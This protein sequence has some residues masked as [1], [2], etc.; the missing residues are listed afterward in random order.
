M[1]SYACKPSIRLHYC[2]IKMTVLLIEKHLL[3]S[4]LAS[5]SIK[6]IIG[7]VLFGRHFYFSEKQ[8]LAN[9]IKLKYIEKSDFKR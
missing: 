6:Q 2:S 5:F 1:C 8:I 3:A 7:H 9:D 4:S